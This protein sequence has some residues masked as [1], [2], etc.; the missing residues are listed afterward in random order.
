MRLSAPRSS[1]TIAALGLL[2]CTAACWL[3]CSKLGE[4][5]PKLGKMTLPIPAAR[6]T[7]TAEP[8]TGPAAPTE[9]AIPPPF[10]GTVEE[11]RDQ[12]CST[13]IVEGLSRQILEE[14][15]CLVAGAFEPVPT[16]PNLVLDDSVLP[17]L[18]RPARDALLRAAKQ[19]DGAELRV[20]SMVRTV[21][22]Q[23]LL[24]EWYKAGRCGIT[25]AAS[26]GGS[27]HEAGLAIDVASPASW[28]RRLSRFGFR[29]LG[30]RDRWHF[31]YGGKQAKRFDGVGVQAFQRLWNRN[32]PDDQ[33]SESGELDPT[34]DAALRNSPAAGFAVG[35][36][37]PAPDAG[38]DTD[39]DASG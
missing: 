37:C 27:N 16:A 3:S 39:A 31:D 28:K 22:Q 2:G 8:A 1:L 29:W 10:G 23:Y 32:H 15:N 26:P 30:K 38:A 17:F 19:F 6:P 25:L 36:T 4:P 5:P 33:V 34:T 12:G 24:H 20:N 18:A 35:P 14:G 7:A 9:P 11:A 21:A 13:K